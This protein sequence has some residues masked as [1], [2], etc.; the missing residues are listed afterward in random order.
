LFPPHVPPLEGVSGFERF[1]NTCNA[2]LLSK[3][4]TR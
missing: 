1:G 2:Q 3:F 4:L